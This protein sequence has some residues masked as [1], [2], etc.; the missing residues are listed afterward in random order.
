M[1][2]AEM[3]SADSA[4]DPSLV[5]NLLVL[6]SLGIVRDE[7]PEWVTGSVATRA[8]ELSVSSERISRLKAD[9]V[10]QLKVLVERACRRGRRPFR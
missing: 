8:N 5:M 7:H 6:V 2:S 4:A 1:N 9:L 10:P 3:S